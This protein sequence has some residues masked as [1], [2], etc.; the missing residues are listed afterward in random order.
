LQK[1]LKD[2]SAKVLHPL[3]PALEKYDEWIICPDGML[4][5]TPWNA[6]LLPD[7]KFTIEKYLI[8][9]VVSGRDLVLELQRSKAK[10]ACI[11]A[12]PDYDLSPS[13]VMKV[14]GMATHD[15]KEELRSAGLATGALSRVARLPGTALEAEAVRVKI[16]E[17]LGQKPVMFME[18]QASEAMLKTIKNPRVLVLAT[19]GY[20]L[21]SQEAETSEQTGLELDDSKPSAILLDKKGQQIENPFLRCGLLLAG[22]NKRAEAKAGEDDGILTGLEIVGMNLNSCELVV[23]SACETGLGDV[24]NGEGVA[25]LRQA[26]HLAGAKGV[27]ASLWQVPDRETALLM[28]AFYGEIAKGQS[29]AAALREAQLHRIAARRNT[30]G[31]AHPF[32]WSAFALTSRGTD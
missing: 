20:F 23:L 29:Q 6:L 24:R 19:H 14:A 15:G 31:A 18:G 2:L 17:W 12:D 13:K 1:P 25:G 4:W 7:G 8:R 9:H 26:F 28:N 10:S 11:F 21:P 5:L 3:L 30:F 32:F 16:E 22:C 27:L